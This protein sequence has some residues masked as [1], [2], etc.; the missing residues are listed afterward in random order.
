[1]LVIKVVVVVICWPEDVIEVTR[2]VVVDLDVAD[3]GSDGLTNPL[4]R[5]VVPLVVVEHH[6]ADVVPDPG[7]QLPEMDAF[8]RV[9]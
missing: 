9:H 2:E 7:H 6:V 8:R 5:V 3:V 1:M 4:V